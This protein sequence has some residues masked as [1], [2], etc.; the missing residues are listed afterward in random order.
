MAQAGAV[1]GGRYVLDEHVG[2][3]G[4]GKVWRATDTALAKPVAVKLLHPRY[5]QRARRWPGSGLRRASGTAGARATGTPRATE[6]TSTAVGVGERHQRDGARRRPW[7]RAG[8]QR[9]DGPE[10]ERRVECS[11]PVV[12][13]AHALARLVQGG[14]GTARMRSQPAHDLV[15]RVEVEERGEIRFLPVPEQQA[16]R[17]QQ[18]H[19][20]RYPAT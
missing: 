19:P 6:I 17:P 14:Q 20:G 5:T 1:L 4:Y 16:R 9:D 12:P 15:A 7:L 11:F 13:S 10:A 8:G 3:G 18:F 2:D